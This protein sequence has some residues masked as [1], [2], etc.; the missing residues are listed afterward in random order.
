M[1]TLTKYQERESL[2]REIEGCQHLLGQLKA[3]EPFFD[4]FE[5][6]TEVIEFMQQGKA[7]D[8]NK[9]L[10]LRCILH[11]HAEDQDHQWRTILLVM[12][13]PALDKLHFQKR[14]WDTDQEDM[15]HNHVWSFLMTVCQLDFENCEQGLVQKLINQT[16]YLIRDEY[17]RLHT[18]LEREITTS[19]EDLEHLSGGVQG[20]DLDAIEL[21]E[22]QEVEIARL[23]THLD[24]GT[25]ND[26]EFLLLAATRIYGQSLTDYARK[27]GIP[28][29]N[30]KKRRLRAEARM[31][32][33]EDARN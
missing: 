19:S 16:A 32:E 1:P 26:T 2:K 30:A 22:L 12:F 9:D 21:R 5:T 28:Y 11:A 24:A 27:A 20:I 10:V 7:R 4:R 17:R 23:Q 33:E 6:W 29:Q 14:E 31:A 15:W 3:T 8:P 13:Y 25:I 18:Q